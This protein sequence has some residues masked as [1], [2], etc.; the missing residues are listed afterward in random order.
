MFLM[1]E[2][3]IIWF[4]KSSEQWGWILNVTLM[5]TAILKL[6]LMDLRFICLKMMSQPLSS[7]LRSIKIQVC[8]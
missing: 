2:N 6:I 8:S 5:K 3:G 4:V 1:Q 7:I